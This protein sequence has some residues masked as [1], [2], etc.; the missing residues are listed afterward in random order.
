MAEHHLTLLSAS[1]E[2]TS[3]PLFSKIMGTPG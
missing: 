1:K 2:S 3:F